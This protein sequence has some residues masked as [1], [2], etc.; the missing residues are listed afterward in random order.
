M[1]WTGV[2]ALV[3]ALV[4]AQTALAQE[5]ADDPAAVEAGMAVFEENCASCHNVDG[6]GSTAGRPLT[7]VALEQP[8]RS[9][10][11][12]SV[13]EG[14]G[15]MPAFGPVLSPEEIDSVVSYVRLTFVSAQDE[16]EPIEDETEEELAATGVESGLL[17]V[18]AVTI[19]AA[20]VMLLSTRRRSAA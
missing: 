7:D 11:I 2:L 1:K 12:T 5:S 9:V 8:D 17:L 15:Q 18:V 6:T 20:G 19:G 16:E 4:F 10:H 14:K 3:F 13:T